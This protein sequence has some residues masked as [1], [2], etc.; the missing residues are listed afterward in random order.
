MV[1]FRSLLCMVAAVVWLVPLAAPSSAVQLVSIDIRPGTSGPA[2]I[3]MQARDLSL[4]EGPPVPVAILMTPSLD[5]S[6][7]DPATVCFGDP[8]NATQRDCTES[9]GQ[10]HLEKRFIHH[11]RGLDPGSRH[12]VCPPLAVE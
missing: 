2:P 11:D 8:D 5:A 12:C 6:T 10:G 4:K 1:W 9:H 3:N 7:V